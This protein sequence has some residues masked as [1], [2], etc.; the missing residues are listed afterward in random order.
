MDAYLAE[1]VFW[2]LE[3]ARWDYIAQSSKK[4]EIGQIVDNALDAIE[5]ENDSLRGVLPKNYSSPELD[6][7]I[8]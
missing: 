3:F 6:K 2:V 7:R 4:A 8:L 1:G 5:K